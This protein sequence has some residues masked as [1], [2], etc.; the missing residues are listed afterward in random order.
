MKNKHVARG[1]DLLHRI[2]NLTLLS[3]Q[4][5]QHDQYIILWKQ[6][7]SISKDMHK[8]F[9][10]C[11]FFVLQVFSWHNL[12][13][14]NKQN[15]PFE[16]LKCVCVNYITVPTIKLH[17]KSKILFNFHYYM[18]N[19]QAAFS[20]IQCFQSWEVKFVCVSKHPHKLTFV[21]YCS[22][23]FRLGH[24]GGTPVANIFFEIFPIFCKY[25]VCIDDFI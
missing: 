3:E 18:A 14:G 7:A 4:H 19:F 9:Y 5:D 17:I 6:L 23:H 20:I 25:F 1:K 21:D 10:K 8:R 12:I 2:I 22:L 13:Y 11:I 24:C 15:K 16:L